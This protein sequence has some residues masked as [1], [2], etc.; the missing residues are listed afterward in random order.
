MSYRRSGY[1]DLQTLASDS[2]GHSNSCKAQLPDLC[3]LLALAA[4]A[5]VAAAAFAALFLALNPPVVRRKKRETKEF[6]PEDMADILEG[7][8]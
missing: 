5:A 7:R 3:Q 6:W 2:Y 4:L 8:M 1:G